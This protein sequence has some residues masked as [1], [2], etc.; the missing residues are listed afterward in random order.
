MPADETLYTN[1]R[2]GL[3]HLAAN[4]S[5]EI[6]R[7]GKHLGRISSSTSTKVAENLGL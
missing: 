2:G 7:G 4:S 1:F 6:Y 5:M 3:G